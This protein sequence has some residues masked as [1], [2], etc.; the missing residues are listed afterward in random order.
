MSGVRIDKW[1]WAARFFKNRALASE[2]VKAG[3]V[4]INGE[5]CK[6]S[7]SVHV[8]NEIDIR[9]E[10]LSWTIRITKLAEKRGSA[11]LAATMYDET[12]QSLSLRLQA[13]EQR[14]FQTLNAPSPNKRPDKHDRKKIQKFK[15]QS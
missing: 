3:H 6:P 7:K 8:G 13:L 12:A 4:D 14:K 1:L 5:Q 9:K 11:N 15:Q 2:A 10:N